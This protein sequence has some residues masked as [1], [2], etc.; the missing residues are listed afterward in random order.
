VLQ[1]VRAAAGSVTIAQVADALELHPNTARF[2]LDA[3]VA[4]GLLERVSG[5]IDGPGR[6]PLRFRAP[7]GMD[8][9]G[10]RRYRL[11]A[12]ILAEAL[13][14]LPDPVE[15]AT[16]A[17]SAW[18]ARLVAEFLELIGPAG[19]AEPTGSAEPAGPAE[20]TGPAEPPDPTGSGRGVDPVAVPVEVQQ[21][22]MVQL[23]DYLGFAPQRLRVGPGEPGAF[24]IGLRHCP[25]LEV[26]SVRPVICSLHLGLMQGAA[27]A[28]G[29]DVLVRDLVP[30]ARADTCVAHVQSRR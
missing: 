8:P 12:A 3:L 6:P 17:G 15:A 19:S 21:Q 11:L 10:P 30:F 23:L 29:P 25:F 9:S 28:I 7:R 4:D 1:E 18:G 26:A 14:G 2:H 24:R 16:T 27:A 13:A 22:R 5:S 20:P